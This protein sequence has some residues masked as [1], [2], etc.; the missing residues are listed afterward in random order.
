[1][2]MNNVYDTALI[3]KLRL[4]CSSSTPQTHILSLLLRNRI[5]LVQLTRSLQSAQDSNTQCYV[6]T[7]VI[8]SMDFKSQNRHWRHSHDRKHASC[9]LYDER[10]ILL[11]EQ[12]KTV[13]WLR[14]L[15][16]WIFSIQSNF[17]LLSR[18]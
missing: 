8:G 6:I 16:F 7:A 12:N 13:P 15:K 3:V 4:S 5:L 10:S 18:P 14:S 1:M 11:N 2:K 9:V 17:V